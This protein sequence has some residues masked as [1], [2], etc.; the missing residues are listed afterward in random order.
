MWHKLHMNSGRVIRI[1]WL[2]DEGKGH[3][4]MAETQIC[5]IFELI[6]KQFHTNIQTDKNGISVE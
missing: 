1:W 2:E 5:R 6:P 4:D 3:R